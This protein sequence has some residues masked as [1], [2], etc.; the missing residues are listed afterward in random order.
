MTVQF[1]LGRSGT[2]KTYYCVR[3]IVEALLRKDDR[4]LLFLVPEQATYQAGR[5]VLSDSRIAGYNRLHVLSFDRLVYLVSGRNAAR[6]AVSRLGRMMVIQRVLCDC[7][8][9]L[10]I[11]KNSAKLPGLGKCLSNTITQLQQYANT[12]DDISNFVRKLQKQ[13]ADNLTT[14]KFADIAVVFEEY[15]KFIEGRFLDPDIQLNNACKAIA[16]A[17][18]VRGA[19]LWVDGFADFTTAELALLTE[20]LKAVED[21][22]IALCLDP[23]AVNLVH[24][25]KTQIDPAD[26]FGNIIQTYAELVERINKC[27]L[28]LSKPVILDNPR[29]FSQSPPLANLERNIF[30][31]KPS[32]ISAGGKIR[33]VCAPNARAEAQFVAR[34]ITKLVRHAGLRYRDIAVIA[35]NI[36]S[37]ENYINACFED[38]A[39]PVFIDKRKPLNHHP[40]IELIC[41][42]LCAVIND[43]PAGDIFAY[44][45]TDL[46]R[47][48][49]SDV[50]LL[51]N[52]CIAFGITASDWE[53]DRDWRYS[54]DKA[55]QFCEQQANLI[56]R[57]AISPLLELKKQFADAADSKGQ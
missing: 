49:R 22:Q 14:A 7:A 35:S 10:T 53:S 21:A 16:G 41:S 17:D 4:P 19:N 37:Y 32:Q 3:S 43:F 47:V 57:K 6:P 38:Y 29:R 39:I 25:D 33:I 5:A 13:S 50:D 31:H 12:P 24:P 28:K 48:P 18:F 1:I 8:D 2:G 54:A 44:L 40:V 56:R 34:Q 23:A 20:L 36:D 55:E 51:E 46:T 45:K 15:L 26:L 30:T 27:K 42:A 52:Y 9:K 11:F